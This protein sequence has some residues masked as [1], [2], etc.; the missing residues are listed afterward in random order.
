MIQPYYPYSDASKHITTA[1]VYQ[2]H[3]NRKLYEKD[4][5]PYYGPTTQGRIINTYP[6]EHLTVPVQLG[7]LS[8]VQP[9]IDIIAEKQIKLNEL[10]KKTSNAYYNSTHTDLQEKKAHLKKT[11]NE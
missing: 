11:I 6:S 4:R 1:A 10:N 3:Y 7:D 8:Y 5:K 2:S 9:T